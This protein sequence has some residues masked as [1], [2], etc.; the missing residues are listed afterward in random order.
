MLDMV[1][2]TSFHDLGDYSWPLLE[3]VDYEYV[4]AVRFLLSLLVIFLVP[5]A[6]NATVCLT[7]FSKLLQPSTGLWK[8]NNLELWGLEG[9]SHAN[10]SNSFLES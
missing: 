2:V 9:Y 3:S 4:V 8:L 7:V 1:G 5:S 10:L 6:R